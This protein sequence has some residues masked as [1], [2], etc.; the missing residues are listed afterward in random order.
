MNRMQSLQAINNIDDDL[1][2]ELL[3]SLGGEEKP[4][5]RVSRLKPALLA[6]AAVIAALTLAGAASSLL[7]P[8]W[9][10]S[11]KPLPEEAT[12]LLEDYM[13]E[14]TGLIA[15]DDQV[16][17]E[18][19]GSI[20]DGNTVTIGILVTM[21]QL[22]S[23]VI[24]DSVFPISGYHFNRW[25]LQGLSD[26]GTFG[27]RYSDDIPYLQK[28]QFLFQCTLT[29]DEPIPDELTVE[30]HDVGYIN[31]AGAFTTVLEGTWKW[32][33][34]YGDT[35]DG[36]RGTLP[37]F[38]TVGQ[39]RYAVETAAVSMFGIELVLRPEPDSGA[40][41]EEE[42]T[43]ERN[44]MLE[45]LREALSGVTVHLKAGADPVPCSL[46]G[47]GLTDRSG[48]AYDSSFR[49]SIHFPQPI[50]SGQIQS[51]TLPDGL[52]KFSN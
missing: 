34:R 10:I 4:K 20:R 14:N 50:P 18:A 32:T 24:E 37:E 49:F 22:D 36:I 40:L 11:P 35:P 27:I 38:V 51:I 1:L 30:L 29:A 43:A 47:G 17:I 13:S 23:A 48:P 21:K 41:T 28:N 9:W 39:R 16:R 7:A 26:R 5:G 52:L 3:A 15:E 45:E 25:S 33:F 44:A 8:G 19:A 2:D 42:F 31:E 46:S 6:L 12:L